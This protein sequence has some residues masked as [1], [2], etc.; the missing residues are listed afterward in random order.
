MQTLESEIK[1]FKN[2]SNY[3]CLLF[4]YLVYIKDLKIYLTIFEK[5]LIYI[6]ESKGMF[7]VKHSFIFS[8]ESFVLSIDICRK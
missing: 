3:D 8:L 7:H 5:I 1:I 6:H 2:I 4:N